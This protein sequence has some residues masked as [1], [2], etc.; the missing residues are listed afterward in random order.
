MPLLAIVALVLASAAPSRADDAPAE[1]CEFVDVDPADAQ[2]LDQFI[3]AG[4]TAQLLIDIASGRV[5]TAEL[6]ELWQTGWIGGTV[7]REGEWD[8]VWR[9]G[10]YPDSAVVID[11]AN[12]NS[13]NFSNKSDEPL[14][15]TE[16]QLMMRLLE[17][18][19][20]GGKLTDP[21]RVELEG[22][23]KRFNKF[24]PKVESAEQLEKFAKF[25]ELVG[26][27]VDKIGGPA[28]FGLLFSYFEEILNL[29]MTL[30][31]RIEG[32]IY[33]RFQGEMDSRVGALSDRERFEQIR[34]GYPLNMQFKL[35]IQYLADK[36]KPKVKPK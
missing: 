26:K 14:S 19:A 12:A 30:F 18:I 27:V 20:K 32:N 1:F 31:E 28:R 8:E 17:H 34:N 3:D 33:I 13:R 11:Y 7:Y 6:D 16:L 22:W 35:Y 36:Y 24:P 21:Q 25:L 9:R 10:P 5:G 2:T 15:P 29:T 23:L 4:G